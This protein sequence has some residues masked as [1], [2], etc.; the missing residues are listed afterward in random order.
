MIQHNEQTDRKGASAEARALDIM[1]HTIQFTLDASTTK[2]TQKLQS[3]IAAE[4]IKQRRSKRTVLIGVIFAVLYTPPL[5][6]F[7]STQQAPLIA[8]VAYLI[9]APWLL[10]A[11][12]IYLHARRMLR[13]GAMAPAKYEL[14]LSEA[15]LHIRCES[16]SSTVLPGGMK[17]VERLREHLAVTLENFV[18][19]LIPL[20][21]FSSEE[22]IEHW[23]SGLRG[24]CTAES[25]P[26]G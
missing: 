3:S 2:L 8:L 11:L 12:P 16:L 15:A 4:R 6:V 24:L 21:A 25:T 9:A 7:L 1:P 22:E 5:I 17:A 18:V 26:A 13:R 20:S 23:Q 10:F 14:N 19:F